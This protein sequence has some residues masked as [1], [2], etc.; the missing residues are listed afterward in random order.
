MKCIL[1]D[2]N[3][4]SFLK[5]LFAPQF[6]VMTVRERGWNGK[7]NRELLRLAQKEFDV[8]VTMDQ[9]LE[10]QQNLRGLDLGVV[11]LYAR[12]NAYP[13]IAP[14]MTKVNEVATLI[15]VGEVVHIKCI[16]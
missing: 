1:L 15:Q 8:F 16:S 9:N 5:A 6:G 3:I 13:R 4:D 14:L 12:S 7:K 2:E 11:V 10:H